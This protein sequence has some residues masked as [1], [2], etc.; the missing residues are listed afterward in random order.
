MCVSLVVISFISLMLEY[1]FFVES[2]P[3]IVGI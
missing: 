2:E 3:K 1:F